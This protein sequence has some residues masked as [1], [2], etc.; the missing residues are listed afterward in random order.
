M[1]MR[2]R[3]WPAPSVAELMRPMAVSAQGTS[4]C[5]TADWSFMARVV[6]VILQANVISNYSSGEGCISLAPIVLLPTF[7]H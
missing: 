2:G 1:E 3:S 4:E 5:F 7:F 6:L